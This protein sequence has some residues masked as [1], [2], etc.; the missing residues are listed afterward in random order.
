VFLD[1]VSCARRLKASAATVLCRRGAV[2]PHG[3]WEQHR[4][5][6]SSSS[7]QIKRFL[8][9]LLP[10]A[11]VWDWISGATGGTHQEASAEGELLPVA[12]DNFPWNRRE[13]K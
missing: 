4:P 5:V 8:I 2:I 9:H 3:Q 7:T 10:F 13:T 11:Y 6:K 12:A 1:K